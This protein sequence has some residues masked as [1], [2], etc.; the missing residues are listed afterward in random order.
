[1]NTTDPIGAQAA[2]VLADLLTAFAD[3]GGSGVGDALGHLLAL[4]GLRPPD[5][6][7]ALPLEDIFARGRDAVWDWVQ[8]LFTSTTAGTAW[9]SELADLLQ[10]TVE[11]AGTVAQPWKLCFAAGPVTTC[12]ELSAT[13]VDGALLLVP[14][15][16]TGIPAP[17]GLGVAGRADLVGQLCQFRLGPNPAVTFTPSLLAAV[18][19][20]TITGASTLVSAPLPAVGTVAIGAL[21][22]G[23]AIDPAGCRFVLEAHRVTFPGT[24][25][26]AVLDLTNTEAVLEAGGAILDGAIDAL[27]TAL[28]DS[29]AARTAFVLVGLR[30]PTGTDEISWPHEVTLGELFADPI[31]AVRDYHLEVLAAGRADELVE[32]FGSLLRAGGGVAGVTG[33]GSD[34]EPWLVRIA[35]GPAGAATWPSG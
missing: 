7:P 20:G 14:A 25:T 13:P 32:E 18:T 4:L 34:T 33:N 27:L 15:I 12:L 31:A 35:D 10:V 6:M 17:A 26:F 9:I 28:G 8:S 21:R 3:E 30:R 11:G 19:V 16:R 2:R 1:M 23:L 5:G 22:T 24:P 29:P